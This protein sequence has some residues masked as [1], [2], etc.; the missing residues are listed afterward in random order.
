MTNKQNE[1]KK[2]ELEKETQEALITAKI[3]AQE[4]LHVLISTMKGIYV[5]RVYPQDG[6]C[7]SCKKQIF[8]KISLDDAGKTVISGC[9]FYHKSF[10]D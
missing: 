4:G 7:W 9:P 1:D 5:E 8:N 2:L 10:C 3:A 6:I